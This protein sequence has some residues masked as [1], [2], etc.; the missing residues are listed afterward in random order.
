MQT[1]SNFLPPHNDSEILTVDAALDIL[2]AAMLPNIRNTIEKAN[3]IVQ[4]LLRIHT[5]QN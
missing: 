5:T 4:D 3:L 2:E 1:V